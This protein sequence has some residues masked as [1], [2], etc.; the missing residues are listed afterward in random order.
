M[1]QVLLDSNLLCLL[2]VG[3]TEPSAIARHRRLSAFAEDDYQRLLGLLSGVDTILSCPHI[4]AEASNLLRYSKDPLR[5]SY[6]RTL[7]SLSEYIEEEWRPLREVSTREEYNRLGL[8][9]AVIVALSESGADLLTVDLDL[10]LAVLAAGQKATNYNH[11]R[12]Y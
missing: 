6:M 7:A 8:T 4:L 1:S 11:L 10:Y 5:R 3:G 12:D 9:D 2:V